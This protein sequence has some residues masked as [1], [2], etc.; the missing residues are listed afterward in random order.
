[1]K[2]FDRELKTKDIQMFIE[3]D[4]SIREQG[5]DWVLLD[6]NR[7]LQILINLITNAIKFT[8]GS[9]TRSI[10]VRIA[11]SNDSPQE[12]NINYFPGTKKINN[13]FQDD[14][15]MKAENVTFISLAVTDTGKGLSDEERKVLFHRFSQASPKTH[16]EYGGSGLG[17]FI[18][19][20]I[21]EMMGGQIGVSHGQ[22]EGCSFAFFVKTRK[23]PKKEAEAST[24]ENKIDT[25]VNFDPM[26]V[27]VEAISD[28][29]SS[30]MVVTSNNVQQLSDQALVL[31]VEDNLINQRVLCTQ[32]RNRGYSVIAANNGE[33]ALLALTEAA[34]PSDHHATRYFD[35][36]LCDIEM[37]IMGGIECV[38]EIRRLEN[39]G[40]L[41]GY[42]PVIAVTANARNEH[43]KTALHAGMSDVTTKP[44]AM[45]ELLAQ[46]ERFIGRSTRPKGDGS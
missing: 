12:P 15:E 45:A 1:L 36:V 44:Y 31:V 35:I 34:R 6:P 39:Q 24:V 5:L 43:V 28:P 46:I 16:I 25:A 33:E 27:A 19:R 42:I 32:L 38:M 10:T 20:Q 14:N 41:P 40:D 11:A 2:I 22:K 8:R 9:K 7:F 3:E 26:I 30:P 18:S 23:V 29:I 37:P 17:L 13:A 4:A 21:T